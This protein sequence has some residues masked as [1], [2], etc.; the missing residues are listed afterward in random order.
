MHTENYYVHRD[1]G[2]GLRSRRHIAE[3]TRIVKLNSEPTATL[4]DVAHNDLFAAL[5]V[6]EQELFVPLTEAEVA[7]IDDPCRCK[8]LNCI[9]I[10]E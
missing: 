8:K 6:D 2:P 1:P 7:S 9:L 10:V 4:K 5:L 3:G